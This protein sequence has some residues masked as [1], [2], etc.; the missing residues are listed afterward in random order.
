MLPVFLFWAFSSCCNR[1]NCVFF[2]QI[3]PVYS[4]VNGTSFDV[5]KLENVFLQVLVE[6]TY[7]YNQKWGTFKDIMIQSLFYSQSAYIANSVSGS[8][9][10]HHGS[11]TRVSQKKIP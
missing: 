6:L 7:K 4:G 9:K 10:P 2:V 1:V 8:A 3:E 11:G 5:S